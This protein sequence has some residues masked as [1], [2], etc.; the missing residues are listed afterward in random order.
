MDQEVL[1]F[2]IE[3]LRETMHDMIKNHGINS[4]EALEISKQLDVTVAKKQMLMY[5][6]YKRQYKPEMLSHNIENK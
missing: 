6:N 2:Y 1:D 5:R 3:N 4:G